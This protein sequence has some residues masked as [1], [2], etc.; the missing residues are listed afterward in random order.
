M[1]NELDNRVE[2]E[3]EIDESNELE[4]ELDDEDENETQIEVVNGAEDETHRDKELPFTPLDARLQAGS[5][6]AGTRFEQHIKASSWKAFSLRW[7]Y[8]SALLL[9]SII[10]LA[11]IESLRQTSI[12]N[13]GL[14]HLG[15]SNLSTAQNVVYS[16][17]PTAIAVIY[18]TLWSYIDADARRLEPYIQMR[19]AQSPANY[20]FLDYIFESAFETPIRASCRRHWALAA[21]STTFLFI[22][23]I[24]P[25]SQGALFGVDIVSYSIDDAA[26]N[27]SHKYLV[28]AVLPNGEFIDQARAISIPN[29]LELPPW[30]S[31]TYAVSPFSAATATNVGNET[32]TARTAVYFA[33]PRCNKYEVE[34]S[35]MLDRGGIVYIAGSV[36]DI[37]EYLLLVV[38][39]T[40]PSCSITVGISVEMF[41]PL[42]Q[43]DYLFPMF[44]T[45]FG[46]TTTSS[47]VNGVAIYPP[48]PGD[49]IYGTLANTSALHYWRNPH[50]SCP[51]LGRLAGFVALDFTNFNGSWS[52]SS[53]IKENFALYTCNVQCNWAIAQVAV[54]AATQAVYNID[55]LS[56]VTAFSD[57]EFNSSVFESYLEQ[58]QIR[59]ENLLTANASNPGLWA[60]STSASIGDVVVSNLTAQFNESSYA[61]ILSDLPI[62]EYFEAG[63]SLIYSLMFNGFL[64]LPAEQDIVTG[65][66]QV[67]T[68]AIVVVPAFAIMSEVLLALGAVTLIGLLIGYHRRTSILRSD[69][70][71]IAAQCSI[72]VDEFA[73][74]G[75][76]L[77]TRRNLEVMSTKQLEEVFDSS[78]LEYSEESGYL[79]LVTPEQEMVTVSGSSP[80][81]PTVDTRDPLPF[82]MEKRGIVLAVTGLTAILI[83]LIF[84]A[85]WSH[86]HHGF[87]Y[88]TNALSFRS[89]LFWSFMPTIIATFTESSW[90]SLHRD[91]CA[92]ETWVAIRKRQTLARESLSLRYSSRPPSLV[93]WMAL[94]RK[95]FMLAFVSFLC[96]ATGILSI[97]MA[98]L[99]LPSVVE[100]IS[101]IGTASQYTTTALPGVWFDQYD[102]NQAFSVLRTELTDNAKPPSW[103]SS[104]LSFIPVLSNG[105]PSGFATSGGEIFTSTTLAIGSSLDCVE[106]PNEIT[107]NS[108]GPGVFTDGQGNQNL[109][110]TPSGLA[111][112]ETCTTTYNFNNTVQSIF[113]NEMDSLNLT[114]GGLL[115]ASIGCGNIVLVISGDTSARKL[116]IHACTP[117]ISVSDWEIQY[118]K[119]QAIISQQAVSEGL[120]GKAVLN[121]QSDLLHWYT[122]KLL[123]AASL[124]I[125]TGPTTEYDWPG[126]LMT[127]VRDNSTMRSVPDLANS[128]WQRLFAI[129]FS[130]YRDDLLATRLTGNAS[131]SA[132]TGIFTAREVR[133]MPSIPAFVVSVLIVFLF[134]VGFIIVVWRRRHRYAGPRMP[135]TIG[136][137]MPWVIH[138]EMLKSFTG[139]HYVSSGD[140][141]KALDQMGR[142][143][144]FGRFRGHHGRVT[145]GIEYEELLM[146]V[147]AHGDF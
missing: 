140:R 132:P 33:Q 107:L 14:H 93:F 1:N 43:T 35:L 41:S 37:V 136:S 120:S 121:N 89:Q 86:V 16:Y 55:Q 42:S 22:S 80:T 118:D 81:P 94:K 79:K 54:V 76:L 98:G 44:T 67:S 90:L 134:L 18:S 99:F 28:S 24:L 116:S 133:I 112:N 110:Y 8:L 9:L 88:L 130:L 30:T 56:N 85:A 17:I 5:A 147:G 52:N 10:L 73:D 114:S 128:V 64:Q 143:Y 75:T 68:Y 62:G 104:N 61:S 109:R 103:T 122:V 91:L 26:F 31:A 63:Y 70:D 7:P 13:N 124:S 25:A 2:N 77:L 115:A 6:P 78:H 146:A 46:T 11:G 129:W 36:I 92:L 126:L 127:R 53:S 15:T 59:P 108:F 50:I 51:H 58:G 23:L 29:G 117:L 66:V 72:I 27:L 131:F 34:N 97:S 135:K 125:A 95:H 142:R 137:I 4:N 106:I 139:L 71:S 83:G 49:S 21:I 111:F 47:S 144:G 60:I 48:V 119:T 3:M 57:S 138:S 145:L 87:D 39:L 96:L 38:N 113:F 141:D 123:S 102:I 105:V 65:S 101:S 19:S 74:V 45:G 69:P 84:L 82:F 20:L 40:T 32:W 12:R 100:L